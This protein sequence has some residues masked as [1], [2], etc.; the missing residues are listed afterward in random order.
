MTWFE[1]TFGFREI[2]KNFEAV[3][4]KCR[5]VH[6]GTDEAKLITTV[7]SSG[8]SETLERSFHIGRF[9][10]P[11]VEDLR[12]RLADLMESESIRPP[13]NGANGVHEGLKFRHLIGDAGEMH[14]DPSNAN[15]V[16][17][18]ASQFNCLEM[19]S[20][21]VTPDDGITCYEYDRTQ[22]PACAMACPAGTLYRN[23]LINGYGQGGQ[24]G[25]QID[26]LSD[27]DALVRNSTTQEEGGGNGTTT[28]ATNNY[29]SLQNGYALSARRG[30]IGQLSER[31]RDSEIGPQLSNEIVNKLR[32]GVHWNTE[33]YNVHLP[34]E[35]QSRHRVAQ[36]YCSA[37]PVAYDRRKSS[38]KD[39]APFA[40]LILLATY[41]ATL[42]T[43]AILSKYRKE[44]VTVYLTKVGGGV[45]GNDPTW[46][47]A[48]IRKSLQKYKDHPL[49]VGLVHFRYYEKTYVKAL[50]PFG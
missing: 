27:I 41:E 18:A 50:P 46:I 17:Q 21:T 37:M 7:S 20:P 3:R 14:H 30:S 36:V 10:T 33:V 29:W 28:A 9:E 38:S 4:S 43:A 35:S 11:S 24:Q 25:K 12:A 39:W 13:A 19:S 32:V 40:K 23:Y 1:D 34:A 48:A 31:L 5:V 49:D 16:F 42:A 44:R 47:Q 6:D 45:F 2:A 8:S 15:A 26:T 22:G